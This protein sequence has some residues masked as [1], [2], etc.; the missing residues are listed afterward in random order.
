MPR[1]GDDCDHCGARDC[2]ATGKLAGLSAKALSIIV[3]SK[4][5]HETTNS[6]PPIQR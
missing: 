4:R 1:I 6:L 2:N 3:A 5:R